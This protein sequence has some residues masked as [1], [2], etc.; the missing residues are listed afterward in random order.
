MT[1]T[2]LVTGG[3]GTVG[4]RL[5]PLLAATGRPVRALVRHPDRPLPGGVRG[6]VG[7]FADPDSLDAALA[8]VDAVFL[9]CGNGPDQVSYESNLIAAAA[10]QRVGRIVKLSARGAAPSAP[11]A[12]WAGH[13]EI[14]R[15]LAASGVPAVLLRPG[16]LMSNLLASDGSVREHG[17]LFAPAGDARIAMIHPADV[18]AVAARALTEPGHD[19]R[20]YTLTGPETIGFGQVAAALSHA[21]GRPVEFVDVTAEAARS[22]L[23]ESGLP[24]VAADQVLAVFAA[25]RAGAQATTTATVPAL[26]GRP[27]LGITDFVAEWC[28]E[29]SGSRRQSGSLGASAAHR[30]ARARAC[31][32]VSARAARSA[33]ASA[34]RSGQSATTSPAQPAQRSII[35]R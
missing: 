31:C 30:S 21:L 11:A 29:A 19:G 22:G 23:I 34:G 3:T 17:L 18:A 28:L 1:S 8:G 9:A 16:F 26:L 35:S 14:E 4:S 13:A 15:R 24:P 6:V 7:D 20:T 25:L 12:F 32:T 5:L 10:R 2:V 27:A 33:L